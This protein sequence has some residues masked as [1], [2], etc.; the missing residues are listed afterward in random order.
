MNTQF[1]WNSHE[2]WEIQGSVDLVH[3]WEFSYP[4]GNQGEVRIPRG[5]GKSEGVSDFQNPMGFP[6]AVPIY[7]ERS[8]APIIIL[9]V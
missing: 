3:P 2:L 4:I 6:M 9:D 1:H 8:G 7:S 5:S